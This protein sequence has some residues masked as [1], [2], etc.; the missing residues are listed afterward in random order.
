MKWQIFYDKRNWHVSL[1]SKDICNIKNV[2]KS[3]HLHEEIQ[4]AVVF[5]V[6]MGLWAPQLHRKASQLVNIQSHWNQLNYKPFGGLCTTSLHQWICWWHVWKMT[7]KVRTT[8]QW[9][10][11]IKEQSDA[12]VEK[13]T[14]LVL[15][16]TALGCYVPRQVTEVST[17]VLHLKL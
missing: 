11:S 10:I 8:Q 15:K 2:T 3:T 13:F 16:I 4:F 1:I 5:L 7:I 14:F 9:W 17:F 12:S 6:C